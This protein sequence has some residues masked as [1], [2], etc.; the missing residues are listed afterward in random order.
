MRKLLPIGS[1]NF[2]A[3]RQNNEIY[4][5]KT[6]LIYQ[7]ACTRGSFFLAR[8]RRFGKSLL[9]STFESLFRKG[10]EDFRGL[11]IEKSWKDKTYQVV[12]LDFSKI[13]GSANVHE[14]KEAFSYYLLDRFSEVGFRFDPKGTPILSQLD[15]WML[16]LPNSSLV[17]LV[18]EYDAPLTEKLN[19]PEFFNEIRDIFSQ[20]FGLM[21]GNEGCLRFFFM[22][23][24]TKFSN[25]SIFSA[26]NNLQDISLDP[27]FGKL[28]GYT[29]DEIRNKFDE[30]LNRAAHALGNSI[31]DVMAELQKNYD[32]FCFDEKAQNH[33]YC[34]WSVLNFLN[35]PDRGFLNYWY[36]SAGQPTVLTKY[37]A[38]HALKSPALY[39]KEFLISKSELEAARQYDEISIEAL[40][41]QSGYLTIKD[42]AGGIYLRLGYPNQEVAQSMAQLYAAEL[43]RGRCIAESGVPM[44]SKILSAEPAETVVDYFNR[45]LTSI[46]YAQYPITNEATCRAYLQVL[47]IGA[48][49][50]PR[51]EVHNALGRS[52]ME[53]EVGRRHWVF[54]FKFAQKDSEAGRLLSQAI[55]QIRCRRYGDKLSDKELICVAL[56]FSAE[57]RKFISWELA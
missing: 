26:F 52:D 10:V 12:R 54:E 14:F 5:D 2:S 1:S 22:T 42:Q 53:V 8:P 4:V 55:E 56:V 49:L 41:A 25:T 21:K 35:R 6:D 40:L 9:I 36:A 13:K 19:Q 45:A 18:D 34:P 11:S 38:S 33:V 17:V 51:V 32:G 24:I 23:G 46:D 44:L 28:L 47:L 39:D 20:F 29:D 30:Y 37:L 7:L 43:L 57:A 48:A 15:T 3:L 27:L 31:E 50:L 16:N